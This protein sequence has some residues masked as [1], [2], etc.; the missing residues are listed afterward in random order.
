MK[1]YRIPQLGRYETTKIRASVRRKLSCVWTI[2]T[3]NVLA[4]STS[5]FLRLPAVRVYQEVCRGI[6]SLSLINASSVRFSEQDLAKR[7]LCS[8][9]SCQPLAVSS[10][11]DGP[12][13][14]GKRAVGVVVQELFAVDE[15]PLELIPKIRVGNSFGCLSSQAGIP[16]PDVRF[17]G[18]QCL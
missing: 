2:T 9:R 6:T 4:V 8:D 15:L 13:V 7:R 16:L 3:D 1:I 17:K 5:F 12:A 11:L 18:V 10:C 14:R